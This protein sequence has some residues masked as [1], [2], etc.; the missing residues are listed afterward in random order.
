MNYLYH[1]YSL[2][3]IYEPTFKLTVMTSSNFCS[4]IL[5]MYVSLVIPAAFTAIHGAAEKSCL[6]LENRL[7]TELLQPML[8]S[9]AL[10]FTPEKEN[11]ID[12]RNLLKKKNMLYKI[13]QEIKQMSFEEFLCWVRFKH[14]KCVIC[15]MYTLISKGN[16]YRCCKSSARD[17]GLKSR[18]TSNRNWHTNMVTH[19]STNQGRCCLAPLFHAADHSSISIT[20]KKKAWCHVCFEGLRG[21]V[22]NLL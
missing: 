14:K 16:S 22:A 3:I 21:K 13:F 12:V 7:L 5:S 17:L 9:Y 6:M 4:L 10:E 19:P 15:I 2:S 8:A 18:R 1:F 11:N 20:T